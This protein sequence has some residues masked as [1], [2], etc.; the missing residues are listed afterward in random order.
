MVCNVIPISADARFALRPTRSNAHAFASVARSCATL[1]RKPKPMPWIITSAPPSEMRVVGV[2]AAMVIMNSNVR[3]PAAL[4]RP[5]TYTP[6][7]T[8]LGER[9]CTTHWICVSTT[10]VGKHDASPSEMS[11]HVSTCSQDALATNGGT[12]M[13][14]QKPAPVM[15]S[16]VPP[17][18][19][20]G[21]TEVILGTAA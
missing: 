8:I 7:G 12:T 19:S 3:N 15:V 14:P 11:G 4:P 20:F 6:T 16:M 10:D 17:P 1:S 13:L 9:G 18:P 5:G 2:M 21:S